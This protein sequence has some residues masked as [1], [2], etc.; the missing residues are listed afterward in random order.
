MRIA[1]V[2]FEVGS[3]AEANAGTARTR[4]RK[5]AQQGA[6]LVVLPEIWNVGYFDFDAY[7]EKA[8]PIDGPT[9]TELRE[10]AAELG[11]YLHTGSIVEEDGED[12]Y[13]TSGLVSPDGELLDTYRKVHLFGYESQESRL[14][15]PGDRIVAIDTDVGTVGLSTC[16]DLRFPE[17]YRALVDRGVELLLVTSAWPDARV[18][19]WQMLNRVRAIESQTFLAAANLT[20]TNDG[21][22]LAGQSLIVDPWGVPLANAGTGERTAYADVDPSEVQSIRAEF[23]ILGD[24]RIDGSYSL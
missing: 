18:E 6:D 2:Q 16:F 15:T 19:H 9:M 10:L 1:T 5:A 22:E 13:N 14:L 12:L 3:D 17:L 8:E 21:V 24:R 11:I 7:A 23:P 20:G 4:V